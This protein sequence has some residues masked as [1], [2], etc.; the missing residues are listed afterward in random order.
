MTNHSEANKLP[1]GTALHAI[2]RCELAKFHTETCKASY[3]HYH[4]KS[5]KPWYKPWKWHD[6]FFFIKRYLNTVIV[7]IRGTEGAGPWIDNFDMWPIRNGFYD[8]FVDGANLIYDNLA[9]ML[10]DLRI[11]S[12]TKVSVEGHSR[13]D[14]IAKL[15]AMRLKK[16]FD[17]KHVIGFDGPRFANDEGVEHYNDSGLAPKTYT[18]YMKNSAVRKLP[19]D[20]FGHDFE[21]VGNIIE[22]DN[23]RNGPIAALTNHKPLVI[24]D[25]IMA[26]KELFE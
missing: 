16:H 26:N 14:P 25:A 2:A 17:I 1:L 24:M 4:T 12:D 11:D 10:S 22:L 6:E 21:H 3:M 9:S 15:V 5:K 20:M 18:I 23:S 13:G 7:N 19:P 8:G